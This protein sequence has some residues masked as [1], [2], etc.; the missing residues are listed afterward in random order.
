MLAVVFKSFY[1]GSNMGAATCFYPDINRPIQNIEWMED[2]REFVADEFPSVTLY[3]TNPSVRLLKTSELR[4][5]RSGIVTYEDMKTQMLE[6]V[7]TVCISLENVATTGISYLR[8][9]KNAQHSA[10]L[11][12][13]ADDPRLVEENEKLLDMLAAHNVRPKGGI[14]YFSAIIGRVGLRWLDGS[15]KQ[16]LQYG[17]T[18]R[19]PRHVNL[20]SVNISW[21]PAK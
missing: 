13:F 8:K 11:I 12:K 20:A 2:V 7:P 6:A 3:D 17:L 5:F 14:M 4:D 21:H 10:L 1:I 18:D 16:K 19:V 15:S 9:Y